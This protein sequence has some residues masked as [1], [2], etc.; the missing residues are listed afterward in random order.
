MGKKR[1][2]LGGQGT[3]AGGE[4]ASRAAGRGG[5][6]RRARR[7][8]VAG[9]GVAPAATCVGEEGGGGDVSSGPARRRRG[10]EMGQA[11]F[12]GGGRRL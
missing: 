7:G 12:G 2:G 1:Q 10:P 3:V 9:R 6:G 8:A 5:V 11:G 4:A